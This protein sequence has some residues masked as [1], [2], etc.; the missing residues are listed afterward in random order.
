[1][2]KNI[3]WDVAIGY[4]RPKK[5]SLLNKSNNV[6]GR[7]LILEVDINGDNYVLVNFYSNIIES[8]QRHTLSEVYNFL[9]KVADIS[10]KNNFGRRF[11]LI[12]SFSY[13]NRMR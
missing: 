4:Y 13:R 5:F 2:E 12:F 1:M 9:K 3:S 11:Q 8:D 6:N 10:R 7:V